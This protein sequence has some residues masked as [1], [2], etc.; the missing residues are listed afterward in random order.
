M[1]KV[2]S[3]E[4]LRIATTTCKAVEV[5]ACPGSG[6]TQTLFARINHLI[7][8]DVKPHKILVL[9]HTTAAAK[10]MK[11]R[12]ASTDGGAKVVVRGFHAFSFQLASKNL[13][14][15]G[16]ATQPEVLSMVEATRLLVDASITVSRKLQDQVDELPHGD[17]A[18][19][20][21]QTQVN[22]LSS[23]KGST[24][25]LRAAISFNR[26]TGMP[27]K[28]IADLD[29][30]SWLS[31]YAPVVELIRAEYKKLKRE[32]NVIDFE[33]QLQYAHKVLVAE[34]TGGAPAKVRA[35][36]FSHLLV[37]EYQDTSPAQCR[38]ITA[39]AKRVRRVLVVGD[40]H[41]A[42][43][44][45]GGARYKPLSRVLDDVTTMTLTKSYR[46][47]QPIADLATAVINANGFF[48]DGEMASIRGKKGGQ[49]PVLVNCLS[50][51]DQASEVALRVRRLLIAGACPSDIAIMA[52]INNYLEPVARSL[53]ELQIHNGRQGRDFDLSHVLTVLRV[54]ALVEAGVT[55]TVAQLATALALPN[56]PSPVMDRILVA[57]RA[58]S[59]SSDLEG[60]YKSAVSALL[61]AL[62]GV[63]ENPEIRAGLAE[64]LP[65]CCRFK[66]SPDM[67]LHVGEIGAARAIKRFSIHAAKGGEWRHVF[68]IGATTGVIPDFRSQTHER[69]AEELKL[70]F[71]AITRAS[72][73]LTVLHAPQ[74]V[75]TRHK[76]NE[77]FDSL[78]KFLTH[79]SVLKC[80]TVE[81][82]TETLARAES[83]KSSQP[84]SSKTRDWL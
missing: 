84:R 30:F 20:V 41:Q 6:K 67:A 45:F 25:K 47:P 10:V 57:Y 31:G 2:L 19:N 42:V 60:R 15:L 14:L 59:K 65:L 22:W 53:D 71:V 36:E 74:T 16:L 17:R 50:D 13:R 56:L 21:A 49:K 32:K 11:Q 75:M 63:R 64:W 46:L 69:Q 27:L 34:S 55:P 68:V 38:L 78:S 58:S 76:R 72:S 26:T 52:R 3:Q 48:T 62:G 83:K 29:Q 79:K 39:L 28:K 18:R 66:A 33:D 12:L 24:A 82:S 7:S 80:L 61:I 70:L 44:G 51:L 54:V 23:S 4:Q 1:P 73:T 8:R 43:Y 37:D 35:I 5:I 9:S 81:Q 77:K 40:P